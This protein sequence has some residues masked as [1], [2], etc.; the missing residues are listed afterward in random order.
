MLS[1]AADQDYRAT[2]ALTRGIGFLAFWLVLCGFRLGDLPAG[3]LA[4]A[5]ASWA[6]LRFLPPGRHNQ[7]PMLIIQLMLRFLQQS[8]AAG[9]DV[10]LR[11]LDPRLPLAPGIAICRCTSPVGPLRSGFCTMA[12]LQPGLLPAGF[13]ADGNLVVHC[14]DVGQPVA[15]LLADEEERFLRALGLEQHHA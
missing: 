7:H 6:S 14:L 12:S 3:L 10:A 8:V 13:D 9:I 2:S 1:A 11:A 4:A 5:C 15:Q